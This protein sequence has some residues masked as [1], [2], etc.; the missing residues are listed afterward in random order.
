M[1]S[2]N[3]SFEYKAFA[4][5]AKADGLQQPMQYVAG[6]GDRFTYVKSDEFKVQSAKLE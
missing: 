6:K 3:Y 1:H 2:G 5:Q 4:D